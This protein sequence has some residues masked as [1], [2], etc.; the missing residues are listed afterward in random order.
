MTNSDIAWLC[1]YETQRKEEVGG[2]KM[3]KRWRKGGQDEENAE[4]GAIK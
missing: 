1:H 4:K 3:R 2:R